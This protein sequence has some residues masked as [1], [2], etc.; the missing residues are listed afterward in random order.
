[1]ILSR[2]AISL[3]Y[4]SSPKDALGILVS[5]FVVVLT[6]VVLILRLI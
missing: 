1:M 4:P 5:C 6:V 3:T 2:L